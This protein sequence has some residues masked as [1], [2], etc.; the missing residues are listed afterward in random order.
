MGYI[1]DTHFK[2][3]KMTEKTKKV[4]LTIF[5]DADVRHQYKVWCVQ[6]N[7]SM[8]AHLAEFMKKCVESQTNQT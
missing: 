5:V 1:G 7:V 8:S 2:L 4:E 6:N 3:A